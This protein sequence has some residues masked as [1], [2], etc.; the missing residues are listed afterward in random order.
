M[1]RR[2]LA[3]ALLCCCSAYAATS[4]GTT[5]RFSSVT[6]CLAPLACNTDSVS[7][8]SGALVTLSKTYGAGTN[9]SMQV[10]MAAESAPAAMRVRARA[11]VDVKGTAA[12]SYVNSLAYMTEWLKIDYPPLNGTTGTLWISY[13]MDGSATRTGVASAFA[14]VTIQAGE[15][16]AGTPYGQR[17]SMSTGTTSGLHT[18]PKALPFVFGDWFRVYVWFQAF[19][20]SATPASGGWFPGTLLGQGT[21]TTLFDNSF[22]L[23]SLTITDGSGNV[24]VPT[25][26]S[27]T[28]TNYPVRTPSTCTFTLGSTVAG[29]LPKGRTDAT[30]Q[31]GASAPGC[32]WTASS[33]SSWVQPFPL[34]GTGKGPVSFT[35]FPNFTSSPRTANLTIAGQQFPVY[36]S[37]NTGT[38]DQRFVELLYF[39]AFGRVPSAAERDFQVAEGLK[40]PATRASLAQGFLNSTEFANGGRFVAGL[41]VGL[42]DRDAEFGGW[43]FQRT[44]LKDNLVTST[45]LVQNFIT[46]QEYSLRFGSPSNEAFVTLLYQKVLGRTPSP[47]EVAFQSAQL[48]DVESRVR[49]AELFLKSTEFRI[50]T[51]RRLTAF[52]LYATLLLRDPSASE[53]ELRKTQI[54]SGVPVV[55]L[56]NDIIQTSDFRAVVD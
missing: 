18:L 23:D 1:N 17:A 44:A 9:A 26:S 47:Q 41:Y 22:K 35:V 11:T 51:D 36:Q 15:P 37:P 30:I 5:A 54:G 16:V 4:P 27:A 31:V 33:D 56:I 14:Q 3:P 46:S 39:N 21:G 42:L 6:V 55:N 52:L 45:A 2:F 8:S 40:P 48:T 13:V 24:I 50:G 49:L 12:L 34:N 29:A 25:V 19:A 7:N 32:P 53:F 10:D 28:G 38:S 43:L 20:G